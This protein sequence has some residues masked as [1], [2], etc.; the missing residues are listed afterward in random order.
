MRWGLFLQA[1]SAALVAGF[2]LPGVGVAQ[3]APAEVDEVVVT[4]SFIGG[5]PEDS[6]LPIEVL[7][8]DELQK[9]G[10]P[11]VVEMIKALT[12]SSGVVG[13][14][15]QFTAGRGQSMEGQASVNLRGLGPER[16]LV[17]LNGRRVAE[18]DLNTLPQTAI[19]RIEVLKDGAAATYG[20]D[21]IAGVVNFLTRTNMNGLELDAQYRFVDGSNGQYNVGAVGGWALGDLSLLISGG[22][23]KKTNLPA[24]KR[25][26]A[27]RPFSQNPEAAWTANGQ[28]GQFTPVGSTFR[29]VGPRFADTGCVPLGGILTADGLCRTQSFRWNNLIDHEERYQ[30]YGEARWKISDRLSMFAEVLY[31]RTKATVDSSPGW[32]PARGPTETVLPAGFATLAPGFMTAAPDS[33]NTATVFFAPISNPGVAAYCAANPTQCPAGTTGV[34]AQVGQ[35]RAFLAGGNPLFDNEASI[36]T[37]ERT[38]IR[39]AAGFEGSFGDFGWLQDMGWKA[40]LG[41]SSYETDRSGF[42]VITGRMQLAL[43]GLGGAN[44]NRITGTPG[45]GGCG[46]FNPFSNAIATAPNLGLTNPGFVPAVANTDLALI[47]WL[48]APAGQNRLTTELFEG[49]AILNGKLALTL[50]GGPVGWALGGQWR[51]N[52][53]ITNPPAG[54]SAVDSPC[55]DTPV[56]GATT[57]N[58]Q[59]VSPYYSLGVFNETDIKRNVYAA[60]AEMSLPITDDLNVQVAVRYEDYGDLGGTTFNPQA[61]AKWQITPVFAIRGSVGSTFRAPP[62]PALVPDRS[63]TYVSVYGSSRLIET[64]GNP[65][66]DPEKAFTYSVGGLFSVGGLR[67]SVDYWSFRLKDILTS[68]PLTSVVDVAF[69]T[70]TTV[71][72][73]ADPFVQSHFTFAG[74]VCNPVNIAT[75]QLRQINGPT[76]RTSGVDLQ[77]TFD[78][79]EVLGGNWEFGGAVS[80]V[81]KYNIDALIIN[82]TTFSGATRAVGRANFGNS[83]AYPLPRWR[84]ELY[85][86]YSRAG[87]NLRGTLRFI[88]SYVDQRVA[89]FAITAANTQVSPAPEFPNQTKVTA[90]Q[91]IREQVQFDLAYREEL[92]WDTTLTIAVQNVFDSDPPFARTELSYDALTA[93][94]LG[95][96][97]QVGLRKRF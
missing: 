67:A 74:T 1:S 3:V 10:S 72:N 13:D 91:K 96:T 86:E 63:A 7:T 59:P 68:E 2:A 41:W 57:C 84:A 33:P 34:V 53:N 39:L 20:S 8:A 85:A 76:S 27:I 50:P 22:Y 82:G 30:A 48:Y 11:N 35:W 89:P 79:G 29:A 94:P 5:T 15:N 66:L 49:N 24:L 56:T 26:W 69:P 37:R 36:Q 21:A 83:L 40:D 18:A 55:S 60:F 19:G 23:Q 95:R 58:P 80:Y 43:R 73:C 28:P 88:D 51:Q 52:R 38:N 6:A 64:T 81:L 31:A 54:S 71:A 9:K 46:Y 78:A 62:L 93:N 77:A 4:G 25:E 65:D 44:C 17:L 97:V 12:I 45:Q 47:R 14:S 70:A 92:P 32:G 61:R 42:D 16:T 90:G 75:V 87:S